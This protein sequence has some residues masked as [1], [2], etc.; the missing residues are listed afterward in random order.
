MKLKLNNGKVSFLISKMIITQDLRSLEGKRASHFT[1]CF[2]FSGR[3]GKIFKP[4]EVKTN[5]ASFMDV[6]YEG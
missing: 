6:E 2:C 4:E 3:N 1:S 5:S